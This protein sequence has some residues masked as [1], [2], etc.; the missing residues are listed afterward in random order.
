MFMKRII[1]VL[2]AFCSSLN[3]IISVHIT[4]DFR[5]VE[6]ADL[7]TSHRIE[8]RDFYSFG[9]MACAWHRQVR[10]ASLAAANHTPPK[11]KQRNDRKTK[12]KA[13]R[14]GAVPAEPLGDR[15][16]LLPPHM[17]FFHWF[18]PFIAPLEFALFRS[19]MVA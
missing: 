13:R 19:A 1:C 7:C 6:C 18:L 8:N 5:A 2:F 4:K 3:K 10:R 16:P 12:S 15:L 9:T 17:A 14:S 11:S